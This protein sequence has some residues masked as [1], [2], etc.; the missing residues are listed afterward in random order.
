MLGAVASFFSL[1]S[2]VPQVLRALRTRDV[3]GVSWATAVM[4]LA[5]YSLWVVYAFSV[6][7][8]VQVVNNVLSFA[9]LGALALAVHRAGGAGG[10]GWAAPRA[11]LYSA[12]VAL[13]IVDMLGAFALAM[14][15]T[16][17][18]SVRMVP[19]AR[20]ALSGTSLS[21]LDPLALVLGWAGMV[22]WSVYGALAGDVGVLLC[23]GIALVMQTV[24]LRARVRPAAL[25]VAGDYELAA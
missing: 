3:A 21:G 1:S 2:V 14:T 17:I 23:S 5:T 25:P 13:V 8:G 10:A 15:A 9:L 7:D 11:V 24:I 6:A 12:A 19:Q 4:S 20:L 22:L 16:A 18:S